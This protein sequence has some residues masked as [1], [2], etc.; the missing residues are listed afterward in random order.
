VLIETITVRI[1]YAKKMLDAPEW[2]PDLDGCLDMVIQYPEWPGDEQLGVQLRM[3]LLVEQIRRSAWRDHGSQTSISYFEV[4]QT[5][6]NKI[7]TQIPRGLDQNGNNSLVLPMTSR[8]DTLSAFSSVRF[9]SILFWLIIINS[10][11]S[12]LPSDVNFLI[13]RL[14]S[15]TPY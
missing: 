14:L 1:S 15:R 3:Q 7:R 10:T 11:H 8:W 9:F 2:T 6:L 5:Q 4:L 12:Q 13:P